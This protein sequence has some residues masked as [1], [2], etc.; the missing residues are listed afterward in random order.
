M[1]WFFIGERRLASGDR[2]GARQAC[3]SCI[4]FKG[5][6]APLA[7]GARLRLRQLEQDSPALP[8][9]LPPRDRFWDPPEATATRLAS[10]PATR[11]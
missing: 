6:H 5:G 9:P 7:N 8:R 11:P 4:G 1:A 10:Q 2:K 3:Q